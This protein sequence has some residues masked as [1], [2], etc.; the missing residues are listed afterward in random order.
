MEKNL[1]AEIIILIL[2][3]VTSIFSSCKNRPKKFDQPFGFTPIYHE[4]SS[5]SNFDETNT[6]VIFFPKDTFGPNDSGFNFKSKINPSSSKTIS[7]DVM[8]AEDFDF[9]KGGK[10]PGLCGGTKATGGHRSDGYNGFSVRVM[11]REG[12]KM[13]SYVYHPNQKT[14]FGDDFKWM[15]FEKEPLIISRGDWHKIKVVVKLNDIDKKNGSIEA[16]LDEKIVFKK[17]DFTFRLTKELQIDQICFSTFFGGNDVS[18]APKKDEKI[19]IRHL[20]VE[21]NP[22][23]KL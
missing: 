4:G 21:D 12:G 5:L 6:L 23:G 20:Q 3:F 22:A 1:K 18:W 10:L 7:Y 13:V 14:R 2:I 16:Y 8:F 11:W 17:D 9:V 15:N 19:F